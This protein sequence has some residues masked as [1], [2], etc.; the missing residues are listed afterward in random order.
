MKQKEIFQEL[1]QLKSGLGERPTPGPEGRRGSL[2]G[3]P[4]F[5][6]WLLAE[7]QFPHL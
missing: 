4:L 1:T 3:V 6:S 5:A 2:R 7:P